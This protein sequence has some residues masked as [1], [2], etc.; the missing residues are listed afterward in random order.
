M[1]YI[2]ALGRKPGALRNGAPFK[3]L[4]SLLPEAFNR[5]R[6]KLEAHKDGDKQFIAVLQLVNKHGLDNVADAC[7]LTIATGGCSAKLVEQYLQPPIQPDSY[8]SGFI[9]LKDPPDADCSIYSKLYLT[10]GENK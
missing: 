3:E 6:N 10:K 2:S 1:H 5:I 4:M 8:E 7:N 9:Q